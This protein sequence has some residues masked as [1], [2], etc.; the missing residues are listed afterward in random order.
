M[1]WAHLS[2]LDLNLL[3]AL[4]ALLEERSV[5]RAGRRVAL[6]QSAT[7]RVLGRLRADF[8]DE[9]L[10]RRGR[11]Y[12]RTARGER[13]LADLRTLLP[14]LDQ[15]VEGDQFNAATAR[16]VFRIASTDH[17]A[18][19][20]VA[21]LV[22]R[23][24]PRAAGIQVEAVGWSP[25][26]YRLVEAGNC[27]LALGVGSVP[28]PPPSLRI[29]VLYEEHYVCLL[30]ATQPVPGRRFSLEEYLARP[31][32][33][34]VTREG[35]QALV[36]SA[37]AELGKTRTV[38]LR[39]PYAVASVL[40]V[41]GTDLV[42]T[43]P[44]RLAALFATGHQLQQVEPPGELA[45]F[46]YA[47]VWH[48]RLEADP[49]HRWL[50]QQVRLAATG[51]PGLTRTPARH[52]SAGAAKDHDGKDSESAGTGGRV[53]RRKPRH[54]VVAAEVPSEPLPGA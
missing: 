45:P 30:D 11:A 49:A 12:E 22:R 39:S 42:L 53:A 9:L 5:T 10:V 7:S 28:A 14:Q 37:L 17:A 4:H 15:L 2:R 1:R 16:H 46:A 32:V 23:L 6:S 27:D 19:V 20:I 31:H 43:I 18:A 40:A 51:G 48:P 13:L 29:E 50:R 35:Q 21:A 41:T 24:R 3:L 33:C 34:F 8:D 47:M 26:S 38:V 44:S 54:P 25:E 36:D 52:P